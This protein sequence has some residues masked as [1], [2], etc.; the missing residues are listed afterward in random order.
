MIWEL[1]QFER[2]EAILLGSHWRRLT[3]PCFSGFLKV[4]THRFTFRYCFPQS[5]P[6][7]QQR[8]HCPRQEWTIHH[9]KQ[10]V[11]NNSRQFSPCS[12]LGTHCHSRRPL[13]YLFVVLQPT[14]SGSYPT[15]LNFLQVFQDRPPPKNSRNF[16]TV[17]NF[18]KLPIAILFYKSR[19]RGF[20]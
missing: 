19:S 5:S 10:L 7:G 17:A 14:N 12:S 2:N 3:S 9:S 1:C 4:S 18:T 20:L 11:N 15:T 13:P 16:P 8:A 6:V